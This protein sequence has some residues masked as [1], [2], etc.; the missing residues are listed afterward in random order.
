MKNDSLLQSPHPN[1]D[2]SRGTVT[3]I[4][5][6]TIQALG[7]GYLG[8]RGFHLEIKTTLN[9]GTATKA[10]FILYRNDNNTEFT[11]L[12]Y[13]YTNQSFVIDRTKS[14]TNPNTLGDSQSVFF[15]LPPGQ[16]LDWHI[17]LDGSVIEVFINNQWA[18]ASRVYPVNSNSNIVDLFA[19]GGN[20]IASNIQIW[21]RGNQVT[22]LFD[23]NSVPYQSVKAWPQPANDR[24]FIQLPAGTAGKGNY[25]I[26][27]Q[28]GAL[29]KK[30]V[31]FNRTSGTTIQWDLKGDNNVKVPSGVYYCIIESDKKKYYRA[32]VMV[33]YNNN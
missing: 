7:T 18:F 30:A 27:S 31:Q 28:N 5:N 14:S 26:I 11:K 29:I 4:A 16:N 15:P 23:L 8:K 22:G 6:T 19:E 24:C 3:A 9:A 32:K 33:L 17:Y 21:S 20:A 12:Y 2:A 1:L 25:Y 13:D 10:G